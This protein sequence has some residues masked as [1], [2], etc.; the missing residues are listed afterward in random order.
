MNDTVQALF[1]ALTEQLEICTELKRLMLDEQQAIVALDTARMEELNNLKEQT[2]LR[3]RRSAE[4][5]KNA[6]GQLARQTGRDAK[7]PLSD[8]IRAL[9]AE[10]AKKLI[11]VQKELQQTGA[12]VTE[13]ARQNKEVLERFLGTVNTSLGFITRVLNSSNFYGAGGTYLNNERTG[14]MIVNRE[15]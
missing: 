9:P 5:L 11:A 3:Q 2:V 7:S 1:N 15:A 10:A 8:M 6:M 13:L 14:A 12:D 4:A